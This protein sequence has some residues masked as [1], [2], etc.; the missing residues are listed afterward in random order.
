M[1]DQLFSRYA[2]MPQEWLADPG[3]R[4]IDDIEK[5]AKLNKNCKVY[6]PLMESKE[7]KGSSKE[8][9]EIKEWRL[10]MEKEE[11]K[12]I[13]RE[14][15]GTA[16]CVNAIARNRGF[17]KFLVRGLEKVQCVALI[18]ALTHNIMRGISLISG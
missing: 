17:Q 18:F 6:I 10:R 13:Y 4:K 14:R 9:D 5:A 8:S 3:Y 7:S 16:E 15:A 12:V 2:T 1:M 11:A